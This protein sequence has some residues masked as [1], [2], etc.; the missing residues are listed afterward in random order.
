MSIRLLLSFLLSLSSSLSLAVSET[1][2]EAKFG[3]MKQYQ[4]LGDTKAYALYGAGLL[5]EIYNNLRG[6][7]VDLETQVDAEDMVAALAT[8]EMMRAKVVEHEERK[9]KLNSE[10]QSIYL[11]FINPQISEAPSEEERRNY[12]DIAA[13][14]E[15]LYQLT[16]AYFHTFPRKLSEIAHHIMTLKDFQDMGGTLP[17]SSKQKLAGKISEAFKQIEEKATELADAL[18]LINAIN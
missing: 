4:S 16:F 1:E 14:L 6:L 18:E 2:L 8:V 7:K 17:Q 10:M 12:R 9:E 3:E 5:F 13:R 11:N 15:P